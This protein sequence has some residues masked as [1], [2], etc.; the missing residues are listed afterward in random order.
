MGVASA[1]LCLVLSLS[2]SVGNFQMI[3]AEVPI[4]FSKAASI[5]IR[6]L[7]LRAWIQTEEAKR[8]TLQVGGVRDAV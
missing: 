4:L 7:T 6:E 8:R 2:P 5:F 1:T 3:S